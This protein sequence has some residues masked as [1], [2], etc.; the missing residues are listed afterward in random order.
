MHV[1]FITF[2]R[3]LLVFNQC[4]QITS[5]NKLSQMIFIAFIPFS[6]SGTKTEQIEHIP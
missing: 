6:R 5:E 4:D 3:V 1:V 2:C